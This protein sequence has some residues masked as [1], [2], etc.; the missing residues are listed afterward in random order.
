MFVFYIIRFK[1]VCVNFF[2][3]LFSFLHNFSMKKISQRTKK[4]DGTKSGEY[5]H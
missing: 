3:V 1:Y 4:L 5:E 2:S